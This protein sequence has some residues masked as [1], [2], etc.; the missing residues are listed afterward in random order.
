MKNWE[1]FKLE[2]T[3]HKCWYHEDTDAEIISEILK[4]VLYK[5]FNKQ[6]QTWGKRKNRSLSKETQDMKKCQMV[7]LELKNTVIE[8]NFLIT[9]WAQ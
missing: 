8:E 3:N 9:E 6:L 5:C 7:I 4:Q 2:K 1:H